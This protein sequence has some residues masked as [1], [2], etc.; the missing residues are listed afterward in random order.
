[1]ADY[2]L[3]ENPFD[4]ENWDWLWEDEVKCDY[5]ILK[6]IS[7]GSFGVVYEAR[8]MRTK[9][10][11]ALKEELYGITR[12]TIMEVDILEALPRHP[13]IVE[14]K[15][16]FAADGRLFVAMEYV[17]SDLRK[18]R[19]QMGTPFPLKLI[20]TL[21]FEILKGLAFLHENGV[22]H[23]DLKP[24]NVL[25][26]GEGRI[27][28]CD[29]GLAAYVGAPWGRG[30]GTRIYKA[31]ETLFE[32]E[33]CAGEVD[34][35]SVGCM[36]AQFVMDAPLFNGRS[37]EHQLQCIQRVLHGRTNPIRLIMSIF[38]ET[39]LSE[40]GLNLLERLLA[41]YPC[42]RISARDAL[43]HPWFTEN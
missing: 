15:K 41:Y 14:F 9:E 30:V 7:R 18:L 12:S 20:K 16:P 5:M 25:Y 43:D 8:D 21:I 11:V 40:S 24:A 34:I 38:G 10:I 27:K 37:D 32:W 23:R 36:M 39:R 42:D 35:W 28:I 26:G 22:M 3:P 33:G 19:E 2:G 31:P 6:V 4:F 29:F 17:E 13:N 1:M